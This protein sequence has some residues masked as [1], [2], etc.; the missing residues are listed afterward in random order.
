MSSIRRRSPGPDRGPGR[1][2]RGRGIGGRDGIADRGGGRAARDL[3]GERI[4]AVE[5]AAVGGE[6]LAVTDH[7]AD[8]FHGVLLS[9]AFFCADCLRR[10][11]SLADSQIRALHRRIVA[12]RGGAPLPDDAAGLDQVAAV[13]D[14]QALL[15]VLLDQQ[16]TDSGLADARERLEQL[17][18][19]Q[20][21][22]AER[23]LVE[24]QQLRRRHQRAADRH[25]L[26]LAAAHGARKLRAALGEA[27]EQRLDAREIV[28]LACAGAAR[29]GAELEVL[30]HRQLGEDAAPFRHQRDPG[31]HD[32]V[33]RQREQ[34]LSVEGDARAR[35]RMDQPGDGL[36]QG[37]LAGAVG[38]EHHDDLARLHVEID[39]GR[40]PEC[41]P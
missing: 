12:Q 26:L 14:V 21:R 37:R 29:I 28:R 25:H 5:G 11:R 30:P 22:E 9:I 6:H 39:A 34:V 36:E 1:E 13:G 17:A 20:R 32:L 3:A 2:R 19:H 31:L 10:G 40:A 18:A 8:V 35:L 23:R 33:R 7:E 38:A 27:R 16:D 24:Q 41:L 15:G 4:D